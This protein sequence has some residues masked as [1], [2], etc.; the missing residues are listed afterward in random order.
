MLLMHLTGWNMK[1]AADGFPN[2]RS[3]PL[4]KAALK[5]PLKTSFN[6]L[7]IFPSILFGCLAPPHPS[8][9]LSSPLF[10]CVVLCMYLHL[11]IYA[12]PP[13]PPLSPLI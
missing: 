2:I 13:S 3:T 8:S 11:C 7:S 9:P 4:F 5:T 12:L 10:G 1:F 6:K